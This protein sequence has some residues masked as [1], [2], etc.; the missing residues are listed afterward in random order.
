MYG[1]ILTNP[2]HWENI[3][4]VLRLARNYE[5]NFVV[6]CGTRYKKMYSDTTNTFNKIPIFHNVE[7]PHKFIPFNCIPVAVELVEG[8]VSLCGFQHPK[9]AVY[10]FGPEDGFIPGRFLDYCKF[11]V[12]ISTVGCMNLA[13]TVACVLYDRMLKNEITS[14]A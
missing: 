13:S 3:G 14:I 12:I 1:I 11:R 9:N 10:F 6:I 5:A 7:D 8:A 4:G 2:K